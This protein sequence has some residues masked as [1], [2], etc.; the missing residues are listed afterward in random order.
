MTCICKIQFDII[1]FAQRITLFRIKL[2]SFLPFSF[3]LSFFLSFFPSILLPLNP[4]LFFYLW[5]PLFFPF[6]FSSQRS[7]FIEFKDTKWELP[8]RQTGHHFVSSLKMYWWVWQHRSQLCMKSV[9]QGINKPN[10]CT[11]VQHFKASFALHCVIRT[12]G[13]KPLSDVLL[14]SH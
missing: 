10:K 1:W 11:C 8:C 2:L 6:F 9:N 13:I 7:S 4:V 12:G 3:F 5:T 14:N